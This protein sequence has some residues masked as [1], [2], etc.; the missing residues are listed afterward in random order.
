MHGRACIFWSVF[1]IWIILG[2]LVA[3]FVGFVESIQNPSGWMQFPP[4]TLNDYTMIFAFGTG[5][6]G[7]VG[8]VVA[9]GQAIEYDP[10][11]PVFIK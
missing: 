3:A 10:T 7:F 9:I 6:F 4:P 8:I 2:W 11:A 5:L 1:G